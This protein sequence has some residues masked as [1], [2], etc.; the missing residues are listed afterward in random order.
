MRIP[1]LSGL[2]IATLAGILLTSATELLAGCPSCGPGAHCQ[3]QSRGHVTMHQGGYP[4]N[5]GHG[6]GC[7]CQYCAGYHPQ[8]YGALSWLLDDTYYARS[9]DYGWARVTKNPIQRDGVK[10]QRQWPTV[11]YGEA[12]PVNVTA[13]KRFPIMSTPVD[14]T[15]FGYYYQ[16][17]PTWGPRPGM[18]PSP[19]VPSKW[20]SRECRAK[21]NGGYDAWVP[22]SQ[23]DQ[24]D[25]TWRSRH[26]LL[27][28]T[29]VQPPV[30]QPAPPAAAN[31]GN[32]N[33]AAV[34]I[35]P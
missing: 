3:H 24:Y 16:Q 13:A 1:R 31:H 2:A 22:L 14:T 33:N 25:P 17:V 26:G 6:Y 10:Y 11:W 5:A 35:A 18:L 21:V 15:H 4:V 8:T 28:P 20:H 12:T 27:Q 34:Y 32:G 23:I 29:P 30:P 7:G 19:P 9:P